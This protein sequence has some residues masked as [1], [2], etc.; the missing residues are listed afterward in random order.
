M[1]LFSWPDAPVDMPP[2]VDVY[3]REPWMF[4]LRGERGERC[5]GS[6]AK[7]K[8]VGGLEEGG[9]AASMAVV[10]RRRR[11]VVGRMME[12]QM[13]MGVDDAPDETR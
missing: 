6:N 5:A 8:R 4:A 2:Y 7:A 10:M 3:G 9:C 11:G 13:K 1:L 12:T